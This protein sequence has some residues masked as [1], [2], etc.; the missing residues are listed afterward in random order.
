[1]TTTLVSRFQGIGIHTLPN[2]HQRRWLINCC[3]A[4]C[5]IAWSYLIH[6]RIR[7]EPI[8]SR[9]QMLTAIPSLDVISGKSGKV[10]GRTEESMI[11]QR[12]S[13]VMVD[14][15]GKLTW[16]CWVFRFWTT[17]YYPLWK[18]IDYQDGPTQLGPPI[19]APH[20]TWLLPVLRHLFDSCVFYL[21]LQPTSNSAHLIFYY[22][23]PIC[24]TPT[25]IFCYCF[26]FINGH[27][28]IIFWP[29]WFDAADICHDP[30][31]PNS[32][33]LLLSYLLFHTCETASGYS[34]SCLSLH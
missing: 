12:H 14:G 21:Y 17:S 4:R 7:M 13:V 30:L 15:G 27:L 29:R 9:E 25:P 1:M 26:I 11:V 10:I 3:Q 34:K 22:S 2:L 8:G 24:F 20:G 18:S 31:L 5:T 33:S 19:R 23:S 6:H 32:H 16:S 28:T